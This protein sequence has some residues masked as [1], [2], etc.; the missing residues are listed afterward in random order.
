MKGATDVTQ[1]EREITQPVNLSLADGMLNPDSIGWARKPIITSNVRGQFLRKKKWNYWC[2]FGK[3]ALFSATI[4]NLDYATVCF[5][6]FLEYETK[7]FIEKTILI[8]LD[9]KTNMPEN[10]QETVEVSH[11]LMHLSFISSEKETLLKISANDFHGQYLAADIAISY[12][13]ELDSLNVVVPW[14]ESKFQ[15][16]AKHH[17]LPA[18]GYFTVGEKTYTFN[19][20]TDFAVLDYGRGIWP[21]ESTWNWGM[22]SGKQN[23]DTIGLNIGGKWTDNTG[24]TENA[25]ILNGTLYKISEDLTFSFDPHDYM[26]DWH[27]SSPSGNVDLT[28]VPFFERIAKTDLKIIQS[29]VHQIVGHYYGTITLDHGNKIEFDHFLGCIEDHY[30]KW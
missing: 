12:P 1:I 30:A 11:K 8:P 25:V 29:E 28:F 3:E 10:V 4:S 16:T 19:P 14:S 15:F 26:K 23:D 7:R 9:R 22:A 20:E 13:D 18:K 5:V 21:Y 17:C 6:Y 27:V 2:V 24:S